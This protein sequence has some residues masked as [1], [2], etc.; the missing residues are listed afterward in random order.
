MGKGGPKHHSPKQQVVLGKEQGKNIAKKM[1]LSL[2]GEQQVPLCHGGLK[3]PVGFPQ[4]GHEHCEQQSS[5]Y[6]CLERRRKA[7]PYLQLTQNSFAVPPQQETHSLG[8]PLRVPPRRC[9]APPR[10]AS[11]PGMGVPGNTTRDSQGC[12]VSTYPHPLS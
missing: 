1:D 7:T 4:Q 6:W 12:G 11:V 9:P 2:P 10:G 3:L 8:L 5:S